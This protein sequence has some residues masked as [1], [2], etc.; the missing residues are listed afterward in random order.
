[1]LIVRDGSA[2]W[3]GLSFL[4]M[5]MPAIACFSKL[6]SDKRHLYRHSMPNISKAWALAF[7][8]ND[9]DVC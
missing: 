7:H 8:Y 5:L 1:M 9:H 2:F 3:V 4:A 6:K